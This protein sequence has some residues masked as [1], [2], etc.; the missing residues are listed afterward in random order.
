MPKGFNWERV[1]GLMGIAFA[2]LLAATVLITPAPPDPDDPIAKYVT[3]YHDHR[4]A[5][6]VS[7]FIGGL[8][9]IAGLWFFGALRSLLR[10]GEGPSGGLSNLAFGGFIMTATLAT[11]G[12]AAQTAAA[13]KLSGLDGAGLA[14]RALSDTSFA[15]FGSIGAS[16]AVALGAA[17]LAAGRSGALPRWLVI[18]GGVAA[19]LEAVT[20]AS[21][22]GLGP[23]GLLAPVLLA[24]WSLAVGIVM[25]LRRTALF[26]GTE[27]VSRVAA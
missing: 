6:L 25:T 17:S 4:N 8:T 12:G 23:L 26:P 27:A 5:F 19:V 10:R 24:L 7:Q 3:Y 1:G 15:V 13:F 18:A 2:I 14:V 21:V 11:V 9:T 20:L 16:L 22:F